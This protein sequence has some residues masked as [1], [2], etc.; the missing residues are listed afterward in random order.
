MKTF[1]KVLTTD[2]NDKEFSYDSY[3]SF[4][5][6]EKIIHM[7]RQCVGIKYLKLAYGSDLW[8]LFD[9]YQQDLKRELGILSNNLNLSHVM[10]N[11]DLSAFLSSAITICNNC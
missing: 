6:E 5:L 1:I 9:K 2:S 8:F 7:V 3:G 10:R 4:S 11:K